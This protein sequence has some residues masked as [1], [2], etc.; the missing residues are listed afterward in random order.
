MDNNDL[1][2]KI[3]ELQGNYYSENQKNIFFKKSQKNDCAASI[4][5]TLDTQT[6]LANTVYLINNTNRI[7]F[8]YN[9][10]KTY[11]N[12]NNYELIIDRIITLFDCCVENFDSYEFH[13][14]VNSFTV[15]ATERYKKVINLFLNKCFSSNTYYSNKLT[16]MYIYNIPSMFD[17]ISRILNPFIDPIVRNKIILIDKQQ[18]IESLKKLLE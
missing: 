14:N 16:T 15:S 7:Y 18:S 6:L 3:A 9:V 8:D 1:L 4:S 13:F 17:Q 11:A 5:N 10:F 12:E 2:K